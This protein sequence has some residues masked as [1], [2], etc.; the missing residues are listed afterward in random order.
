MATAV[1]GMAMAALA[2]SSTVPAKSL[3]GS[4]GTSGSSHS[5][6]RQDSVH[7]TSTS[8]LTATENGT[9][10]RPNATT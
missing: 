6:P 9:P 8:K 7:D 10:L 3:S 5:P 1:T 4:V 2:T